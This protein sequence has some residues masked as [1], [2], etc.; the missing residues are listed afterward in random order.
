MRN[1]WIVTVPRD[2]P[3]KDLKGI[4]ALL[5]AC[6]E[7][8]TTSLEQ[9]YGAVLLE[10]FGSA[11]ATAVDAGSLGGRRTNSTGRPPEV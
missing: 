8:G 11:V 10:Q 6:E 7:R 2:F 3:P 4:D 9:L 5:L 1:T